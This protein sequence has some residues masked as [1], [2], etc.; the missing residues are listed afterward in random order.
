MD[1]LDLHRRAQDIFRATVA[2]VGADQWNLA[3]PCEG[4]SVVD[5]V[6]HIIGGNTWVQGLAGR[7]PAALPE[8]DRAV[9]LEMSAD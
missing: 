2:S 3:T 7:E 6:D 1:Q 4:W 8:N 5:L 9:A